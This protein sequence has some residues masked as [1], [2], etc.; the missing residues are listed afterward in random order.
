M[1]STLRIHTCGLSSGLIAVQ[2]SFQRG[3]Q[4]QL[5]RFGSVANGGA[6]DWPC[7]CPPP[8]SETSRGSACAGC[9]QRE[10][11]AR[12]RLGSDALFA[13]RDS[14]IRLELAAPLRTVMPIELLFQ[15]RAKPY[16]TLR[17]V[18]IHNA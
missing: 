16:F 11:E 1:Y 8:L 3:D 10:V 18:A 17:E 5:L 13:G 6:R 14:E 9:R 2:K 15:A 4:F 7:D 12:F